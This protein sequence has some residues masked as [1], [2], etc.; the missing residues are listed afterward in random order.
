MDILYALPPLIVAIVAV[1]VFGGGY[2]LAIAV[3]IVLNLPHNVRLLRAA[4]VERR[5]L[6]FVEAAETLGVSRLRMMFVHLLPNIA[7][8]V[9]ACFFL[10]FT[11]GIV[12]L[13]SLSFLGLGVPP[14]STDW[15][16]MLAENRAI[17]FQNL[18]AALGPGL[19][20]VL[21]AVS[22]NIVGDRLYER[23]ERRGRER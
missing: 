4:V 13:S 22:A 5:H 17:I 8:V 16:R 3:L 2:W 9:A 21:S 6:P 15:G 20:L 11:Y 7:P 1:G 14:G 18:W 23:F 10:R 19:A 12:D